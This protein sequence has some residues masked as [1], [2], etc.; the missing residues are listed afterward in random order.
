[1]LELCKRRGLGSSSSLVFMGLFASSSITILLPL[2]LIY[3][4][5]TGTLGEQ[6]KGDFID[7][8]SPIILL[9]FSFTTLGY[10]IIKGLWDT[11]NFKCDDNYEKLIINGSEYSSCQIKLYLEY[12][13]WGIGVTFYRVNQGKVRAFISE[14]SYAHGLIPIKFS[15]KYSNSHLNQLATIQN[16]RVGKR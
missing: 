2:M 16:L 4:L 10:P 9:S 14:S 3:G 5:V 12:F 13:F 1:M 7:V 8:F 11:R 6:A 15:K